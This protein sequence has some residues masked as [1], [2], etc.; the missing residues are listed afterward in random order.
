MTQSYFIIGILQWAKRELN[1]SLEFGGQKYTHFQVNF[2]SQIHDLY[3]RLSFISTGGKVYIH[4]DI[5]YIKYSEIKLSVVQYCVYL[6][7]HYTS[8]YMIY[9]HYH[10]Y[11]CVSICVCVCMNGK[12]GMHVWLKSVSF[13]HP[14]PPLHPFLHNPQ[15]FQ[16]SDFPTF[17]FLP[18]F[19]FYLLCTSNCLSSTTFYSYSTIIIEPTSLTSLFLYTF[20]NNI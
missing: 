7:V 14:P 13:L 8:I 20:T 2:N 18:N 6:C 4:Y 12:N 15:T 10:M 19:T 17:S 9:I 1:Y 3:Y 5:H 11:A 16:P